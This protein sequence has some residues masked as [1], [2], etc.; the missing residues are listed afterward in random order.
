M[1]VIDEFRAELMAKEAS[2]A[3]IKAY[4]LDLNKFKR[5]YAETVGEKPLLKSIGPLDIAEFKRFLQ[6]Q[7]QKP[8]TINRAIASLRVFFRWAK[9]KG[10]VSDDPTESIKR[11][12][13]VKNA[14][15]GLQRNEQ[16]ALMRA[17]MKEENPRDIAIVTL[18][19][20]TGLR[21]AELCNLDINDVLLRERSGYLIVK[22]GKGNKYREVPLNATV[23]NA[24]RKW[25]KNRGKE[26]GPLFPN[27][28]G[29][30]LTSRNIQYMIAKYAYN[31]RLSG[32]TPHTLRHT[33]CKALIDNGVSIDR[34]AQLAGH[35]DLNTTM[36]YTKPTRKDLQNTVEK[37]AW[38]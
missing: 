4:I 9:E 30:P 31:A 35:S 24:L 16:Q 25:L 28:K 12:R 15:S 3:T 17:V 21:V 36:L 13:V 33:F 29:R 23:R 11:I 32:V 22:S 8:A 5:W 14:P 34:V 6:T 37:I 38:E 20:H 26:D 7:G 1:D 19:L 10:L 18:L 2:S 27:K